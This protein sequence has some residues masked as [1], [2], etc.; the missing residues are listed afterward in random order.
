MISKLDF[1]ALSN[2][3]LEADLGG[4]HQLCKDM[5]IY[6]IVSFEIFLPK[7]DKIS[8]ISIYFLSGMVLKHIVLKLKEILEQTTEYVVGT[9][10]NLIS[11]KF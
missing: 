10:L 6:S 2:N 5:F 7:K 1:S 4:T 8:K 11:Q 3:S 9:L